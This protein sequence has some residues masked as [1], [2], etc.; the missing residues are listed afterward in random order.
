MPVVPSRVGM[1]ETKDGVLVVGAA[2]VRIVPGS[3]VRVYWPRACS[4]DYEVVKV[5]LGPHAM[6]NL[7]VVVN[8]HGSLAKVLLSSLTCQVEVLSPSPANPVRPV[9]RGNS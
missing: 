6:V 4:E 2:G 5:I 7:G 3:R 8:I 9:A 1:V